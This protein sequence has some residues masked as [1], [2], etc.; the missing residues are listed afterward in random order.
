MIKFLVD[1]NNAVT[2]ITSQRYCFGVVHFFVCF[3]FILLSDRA[4]VSPG[5]TMSKRR[6]PNVSWHL[7]ESRNSND[8]SGMA[9]VT[10]LT[11][12]WEMFPGRNR[13]CCDGRLMMAPHAAVFYINVILIIGTSFLFFVFEWVNQ[14]DS[15]QPLRRIL[16][17][18]VYT[19]SLTHVWFFSSSCPYL[20]RRVTPV[21]PII[22]GVLFLFVI[23]SLFK[24]SFTDPGIIPRATADEAAYI[25]K[26]VCKCCDMAF[27]SRY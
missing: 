27:L 25:E 7:F 6:W 16:C 15:P 21:I 26:Q 17:T 4:I 24:T 13:F 2:I 22:S 20:S 5:G 9:K 8:P 12:K 23:G 19:L 10:T 3:L 18:F 11:R 14:T 1:H